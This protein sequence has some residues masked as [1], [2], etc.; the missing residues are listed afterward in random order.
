MN[1]DPMVE[2]TFGIYTG[3]Y[4]E[5]IILIDPGYVG[6]I[7]SL[8][9]PGGRMRELWG[10]AR[11]LGQIMDQKPFVVPCCRC[12]RPARRC[13][14][15]PLFHEL[16]F[17]CEACGDD[18]SAAWAFQ[19]HRIPSFLELCRL[20]Q[21]C[22]P[23]FDLDCNHAREYAVGKGFPPYREVTPERVLR[24]FWRETATG[25]RA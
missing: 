19:E 24:F 25:S 10:H 1:T 17:F 7:L 13:T 15:R 21:R 14:A 3:N 16:D 20:C 6:W 11:R 5:E 2:I 22:Q 18:R 12:S 23:L 9:K 8:R 4:L